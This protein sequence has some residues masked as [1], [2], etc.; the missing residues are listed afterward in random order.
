[1]LNWLAESKV[2]L[3]SFGPGDE[4]IYIQDGATQNYSASLTPDM[5]LLM[6]EELDQLRSMILA[7]SA[8]SYVSTIFYNYADEYGVMA[9]EPIAQV[10]G[11]I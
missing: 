1:M 8:S 7:K 4:S 9:A 3:F 6:I 11:K 2:A 5:L 10:S